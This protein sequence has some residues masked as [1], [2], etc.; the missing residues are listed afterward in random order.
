[1]QTNLV[2]I[3]RFLLSRGIPCAVINLTRYR[4]E[5]GDE[6]YYPKSAI[7]VLRLLTRLR[8]D[9]IHL[10]FGGNLS[11]R[12]MVLA[13]A[14][15]LMPRSKTVLTLHSGGYPLSKAGKSANPRTFRGF[16]LRQFDRVIGVNRELEKLFRRF[17]VA[18]GRIR[19]I[20]PHA[21][22][23]DSI[24]SSLPDY[25]ARFFQ[26]H[27]PTLVTVSGLEPEYDLSLQINVLGEVRRRFPNAGLVIIGSGS[28]EAEVRAQTR[29]KTYAEHIL[30]CGD[31]PHTVTLRAIAESD[32]FL[33]T[34]LYDGDSIS[35]RESLLIGT[36]VI[37]TD[38]GMRPAGVHLI[39]CSSRDAL[40][41]TIEKV[42]TQPAPER[43]RGDTGERNIE[44]VF[45]LY[46]EVLKE[47]T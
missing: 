16:V 29:S 45:D 43:T 17:G 8:Y 5:D 7:E 19:L 23:L 1:V 6:I 35:V 32:L 10:H 14:C 40:R 15:C 44:E 39:P 26:T 4:R 13:L 30:L 42:L 21:I 36:P 22:S 12:L 11:P 18:A 38:N 28:L 33:R 37:A 9:I 34:T 20:F 46:Q 47:K 24:E 31:V 41:R 25:L 2:A 3:R 27:Y